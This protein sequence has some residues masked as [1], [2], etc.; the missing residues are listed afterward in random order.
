MTAINDREYSYA[1]Q[2]SEKYQVYNARWSSI[3]YVEKREVRKNTIQ[4]MQFWIADNE[5]GQ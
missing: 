1:N 5:K 2:N 4:L 3:F